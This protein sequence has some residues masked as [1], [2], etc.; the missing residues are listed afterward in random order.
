MVGQSNQ[1][2]QTENRDNMLC[3]GTSSH[4]ASKLA[5]IK[6]PQADVHTLE[7]N[8]ASKMRNAVNNVM[9]SVETRVQDAVLTAKK[10]LVIPRMELAMK[11]ANAHSEQSVDGNVLEPD[12]RDFLGNIEGLRIAASVE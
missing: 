4:N 1:D 9:T 11:S 3:R 2:E 5:Q 12:Q 8:I 7:A 6:Y 10:N